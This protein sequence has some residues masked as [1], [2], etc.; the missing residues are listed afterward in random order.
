MTNIQQATAKTPHNPEDFITVH[1][2]AL[3][4]VNCFLDSSTSPRIQVNATGETVRDIID[5]LL[6]GMITVNFFHKAVLDV[7]SGL[8]YYWRKFTAERCVGL[9]LLVRLP[10]KLP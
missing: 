6:A 3:A 4:I 1:K 8:M 2:K 7:F 10:H 9:T 5:K